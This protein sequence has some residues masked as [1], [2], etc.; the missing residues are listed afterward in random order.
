LQ[1]LKIGLPDI[2][3]E[4]ILTKIAVRVPL[5]PWECGHADY[6]SSQLSLA[7]TNFG[8]ASADRRRSVARDVGVSR[9]GKEYFLVNFIPGTIGTWGELSHERD[10]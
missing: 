10:F 8:A 3:N 2:L 9:L 4:H 5:A 1:T 7:L 6:L